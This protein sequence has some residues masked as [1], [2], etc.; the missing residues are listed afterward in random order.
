M[1]S[2]N[3]ILNQNSLNYLGSADALTIT[4][5]ALKLINKLYGGDCSDLLIDMDKLQNFKLN[6]ITGPAEVKT[7][8]LGLLK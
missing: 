3:G 5:F 2:A 7:K 4:D 8:G 1:L 6:G